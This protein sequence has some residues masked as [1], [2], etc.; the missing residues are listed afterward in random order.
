MNTVHSVGTEGQP[1][2][3]GFESMR[4]SFLE[5][6]R[7]TQVE[8]GISDALGIERRGGLPAV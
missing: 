7:Q 4:F 3:L 1:A 2:G 6:G 5:E 8:L